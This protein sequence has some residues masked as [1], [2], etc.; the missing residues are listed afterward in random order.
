MLFIVKLCTAAKVMFTFE[1]FKC[2]LLLCNIPRVTVLTAYPANISMLGQRCFNVVNQCWNNV[3]PTLKMKKNP[4]SNFQRC[5]TLIQ[6]RCA[7]LKQCWNNVDTVLSQL[8]SNLASTL[9]K[10]VSKPIGQV[11]SKF[12]YAKYFGQY[13]NN[14]TTHKLGNTYSNFLTVHMGYKGE[15]GETQKSSNSETLLRSL[16]FMIHQNLQHHAITVLNLTRN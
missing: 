14:S 11:I 15:N 16:D 9:V 1:L 3:D 5:T 8:C 6:H 13:I 2:F 7:T 10:A 12:Y 4:M